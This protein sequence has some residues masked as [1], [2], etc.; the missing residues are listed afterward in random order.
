MSVHIAVRTLQAFHAAVT[1]DQGAAFRKHL[2]KVLPHLGD[3]YRGEDEGFRSHLGASGIGK[4]CGRAIWYGFRW[5]TKPHFIGRM[6][7]L[8]NRG[9][10]EEGRFIALLLTIG[11]QV[12]QQD[13]NGKQ[14]RISYFGGHYG[15]SGD[16]VVIGIPDVQP[17]QPGLSEFKTHNNKSFETI[18]G[19]NWRKY[20]DGVLGL[21]P[22]VPFDGEGVRAGKFEHWIQMQAYMRKMGLAWGIYFACNKDND[23]IYA[24]I[25]PLDAVK[26]D[27]FVERARVIVI[28][29]A[30]PAKINKTFNNGP[31]RF[32]DYHGVCKGN[33]E[34]ERNCRTC[35]YLVPIVEGD[36]AGQWEC[37][38]KT[39]RLDMVFGPK[40]GVSL[41]GEN[42][43]PTKQRQLTGCVYYEKNGTM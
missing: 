22:V 38:H 36:L 10:L 40:E 25:V 42:F 1:H 4:E 13:E 33:A 30:A 17:G 29:E 28:A 37:T 32:C 9:H 2:E 41:E 21:G 6:I 7:R 3:A 35:N 43:F 12:F 11:V 34:P 23:H 27:E 39:R 15:G 26:A 24:E 16:G 8:F 19:K 14:F 5:A 20:E 31:C 18:A